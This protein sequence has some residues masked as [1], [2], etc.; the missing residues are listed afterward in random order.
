M[1]LPPPSKK[2]KCNHPSLQH[3]YSV[4]LDTRLSKLNALLN[5]IYEV[6]DGNLLVSNTEMG[7]TDFSINEK[8]AKKL[9]EASKRVAGLAN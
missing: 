4:K 5:N 1:P 2:L 9:K 6:A 3:P 7:L 8:F